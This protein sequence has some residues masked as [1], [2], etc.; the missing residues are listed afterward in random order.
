MIGAQSGVHQDLPPNGA[1]TGSP[2]IAHRDF[3]RMA[4][5]LPKVPEMRKTLTDLGK[6]LERLEQSSSEKKEK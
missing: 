1:Y 6:R 3:L 5:T 4:M 2:A